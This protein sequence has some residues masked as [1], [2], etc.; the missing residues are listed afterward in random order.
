MST[1]TKMPRPTHLTINPKSA[2]EAPPNSNAP[3]SSPVHFEGVDLSSL[4]GEFPAPST[5][6]TS[7]PPLPSSPPTSPRHHRD[8]SKGILRSLRNRSQPDHE[9]RGRGRQIKQVKGEGENALQGSSSVAQMYKLQHRN[10]ST[11]ELSLIGSADNVNGKVPADGKSR[12]CVSEGEG[13]RGAC[14]TVGD[15]VGAARCEL[16]SE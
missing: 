9:A 11:P 4:G 1:S 3:N 12:A 16:H 13:G 6:L 7:L 14:M 10:G 15:C 5:T 2:T 8:P